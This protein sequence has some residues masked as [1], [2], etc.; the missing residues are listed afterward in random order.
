MVYRKLLISVGIM[1]ITLVFTL[2]TLQ[3]EEKDDDSYDDLVVAKVGDKEVKYGDLHKWIKMMPPSYQSM[4]N[5][6]EQMQKL[7]DRQINNILFSDEAIRLKLDQK[8]DVKDKID[9][10]TK[11]ILMQALVE[12]KVN[13][14]I[15]VSDKEVEE[16]YTSHQDEFKIPE[17]IKVSYILIKVDP[18]AQKEVKDEKKAK[19]EEILAKAKAG[20]DFSA[21]AKQYSE[22]TKTKKKGGVL[23]FFAKGSK[24]SEFEKAAFSLKK[25]EISDPILTKKGYNIIKLIDKKEGR[26]KSLKEAS[27]KIRNKLKQK[28]RNEAIENLLNDLKAKSKVVIYEDALTKVTEKSDKE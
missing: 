25:N 10:F 28:G 15:T 23:S 4:F 21:L 22:D 2:S 14:N 26:T 1:A 8:P 24:D 5:N 19:A 18:K 9:E 27:N 6:P 13:K 3:A 7:L 11:G 17:K 12:E 20:E 16:Y